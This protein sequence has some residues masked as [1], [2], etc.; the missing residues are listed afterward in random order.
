MGKDE[1]RMKQGH[2]SG[3]PMSLGRSEGPRA[4]EEGALEHADPIRLGSLWSTEAPA[5]PSLCAHLLGRLV[6]LMETCPQGQRPAPPAWGK[7]PG[8]PQHRFCSGFG[9]R[10]QEVAALGGSLPLPEGASLW[11]SQPH[12]NPLFAGT[13]QCH[14]QDHPGDHLSLQS[15]NRGKVL[16]GGRGVARASG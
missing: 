12:P 13:Q 3:S 5:G 14:S 7:G 6:V 15:K 8:C 2:S 11:R 4:L 10:P 9:S 16:P 1:A